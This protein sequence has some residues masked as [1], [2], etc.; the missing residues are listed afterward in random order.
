MY[1]IKAPQTINTAI[2]LPAS[3]SISNR[4]L[5]LNA[6][7]PNPKPI[8]NLSAC[9]DTDVVIKALNVK[10]EIIDVGA[11][12]TAMRFLTAYLAGQQGHHII[13]GTER[14][15]NRP[16]K[17]LVEA[18]RSVGANIDYL[19]KDGF[20]PLSI[21]GQ[22]LGGGEIELDGSVSSQFVSALLMMAPMMTNGLRL[23][24][25]G[26]IISASYIGITTQL[27]HRYGVNVFEEGIPPLSDK[28]RHTFLF[29]INNI[30]R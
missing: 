18:L 28:G 30:F 10:L 25:T 21:E 19:E 23:H 15:K 12:G 9:D 17:L 16:V 7:C 6:L 5:I 22:T 8:R 3:K 1:H 26:R 24:L 29:L 4:A 13:T 27:M 14:M 2:T 11:A 20:P